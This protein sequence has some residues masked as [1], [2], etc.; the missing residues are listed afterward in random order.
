MHRD[1]LIGDYQKWLQRFD[2]QWFA[3]L[4]F[5]QRPSLSKAKSL[6]GIWIRELRQR[7]GTPA[8]I[9][10]CVTEFGVTRDNLHFHVLIG[11]LND[12]SSRLPAIRL[13][14]K[15]AGAA[16]IPY[17]KKGKAGIPYILK[18]LELANEFQVDFDLDAP[19]AVRS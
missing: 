16:Q 2:F 17:F 9:W 5:R 10:F 7:N 18:D 13:W 12:R 3:T 11:G 14:W 19:I 8:F 1:D 15:L 6:R 4:T